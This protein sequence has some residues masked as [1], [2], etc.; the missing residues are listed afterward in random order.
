V[1]SGHLS[2]DAAT[3]RP[4]T[5]VPVSRLLAPLPIVTRLA[6]IR[7]CFAGI[8]AG[9]NEPSTPPASQ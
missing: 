6:A 4:Q 7:L 1:Q 3:S 2:T 5:G 8:Q 9:T